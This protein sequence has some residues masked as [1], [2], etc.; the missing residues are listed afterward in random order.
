MDDDA[1]RRRLAAAG[2]ER[3]AAFTWER[4]ADRLLDAIGVLPR[5]GSP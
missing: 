3:A 1:L 4:T 5:G 2:R